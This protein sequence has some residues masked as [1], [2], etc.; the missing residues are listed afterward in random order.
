MSLHK[1]KSVHDASSS[2]VTQQQVEKFKYFGVVFISEGRWNNFY[3]KIGKANIVLHDFITLWS[4]QAPQ[5]FVFKSVFVPILT[6]VPS[7]V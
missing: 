2:G 5:N 1:P 7:Q 6:L 4:F 3:A